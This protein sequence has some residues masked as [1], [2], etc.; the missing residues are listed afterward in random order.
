MKISVL[1]EKGISKTYS[2]DLVIVNEKIV[3]ETSEKFKIDQ[4]R[5]IGVAD[6]VGGNNGGK[7]AASF[8]LEN[9]VNLNGDFFCEEDLLMKLKL[10]NEQMIQIGKKTECNQKMATVFSGIYM[11][12][13][14]CYLIHIGNT[15]LYVK[16]GRFLQCLT[17]DQTMK[18][19][20]ERNGNFVAADYSNPSEIYG[21]FGGGIAELVGFLEIKE[22]KLE[23][24]G[25][26][27]LLTS[28]GIHEYV[29]VSFLEKILNTNVDDNSMLCEISNEAIKNGSRDDRSIV[30]IHL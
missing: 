24:L 14:K 13:D 26:L 25:N 5:I 6:G 18:A 12:N 21:C 15:R 29:T 27:L 16:Q 20:Y 3:K 9:L 2:E 11:G 17:E 19:L 10:I 23:T 30:I 4:L 22:I 28:D 8:L 1:T 7:E